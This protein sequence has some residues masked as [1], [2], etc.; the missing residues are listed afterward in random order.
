MGSKRTQLLFFS[1]GQSFS[2]GRSGGSDK[3]GEY[4]RGEV[5]IISGWD[6]LREQ[7][8]QFDQVLRFT[9]FPASGGINPKV[10]LIFDTH[11]PKGGLKRRGR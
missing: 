4:L 6:F 7:I 2:V 5:E 11:P 1:T 10:N 3:Q 9:H 8:P